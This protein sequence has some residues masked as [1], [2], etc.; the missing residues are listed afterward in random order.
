MSWTPSFRGPSNFSMKQDGT[1]GS[2]TMTFQDDELSYALGKQ[3]GTR[4]RSVSRDP[5]QNELAG[6]QQSQGQDMGCL[7]RPTV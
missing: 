3:G 5:N 7:L 2:D 6:G 4:Q 1:W